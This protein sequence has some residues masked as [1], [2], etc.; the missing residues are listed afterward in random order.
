ML[1]RAL[2]GDRPTMSSNLQDKFLTCRNPYSGVRTSH[3]SA[4]TRYRTH[5]PVR[6]ET[7]PLPEAK[8]RQ[9]SL[10][11]QLLYA[12]GSLAFTWLERMIILYAAFFYLPPA[13]LG[14]PSLISTRTY[15]GIFTVLGLS[16]LF[17]RILDGLADPVIAFLSDRSRS[18]WG[19]RKYFLLLSALPLA[20]TA[21]LVFFPPRPYA[22]PYNGLWLAFMLGAFYVFFTAYVNPY[23]S[24]I[25]GLG[26]SNSARVNLSTYMALFG[27]VGM[28]VVTVA[29]PLAIGQLQAMGY[30]LRRAYQLAASASAVLG[31]MVLYGAASAF[32][33]RAHCLPIQPPTLNLWTSARR[34]LEVRPFRLF[35]TAEVF[36]QY[37]MNLVTLGLMYFTVVLFRRQP[38]FLTVLAGTTIGAALVS[39]PLVNVMSKRLGKKRLIAFAMSTLALAMCAMLL[40]SY[41]LS[42]AAFYAGIGLFAISGIPLAILT[43]LINPTI[44]ELARA[45]AL[46][47]GQHCEAMFFAVRSI[48]LKLSIAAAGLSFG[49]LL[50]RFGKD[51]ADPGGVRASLFLVSLAAILGYACFARYPE[52]QV[53]A[54]LRE[55]EG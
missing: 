13:E 16:L 54:Q 29:F 42:G 2:C 24:L 5:R 14:L 21:A 11:G 43:I 34:T 36:L 55:Y 45:E 33:E 35:I 27:L 25:S 1:H 23:L 26:H 9:L 28:L 10:P 38:Q 17:G 32:G 8:F 50:S 44:A 4:R 12:S 15:G 6:S 48:P 7:G 37:A 39:F 51:V 3:R 49:F 20:G 41:D 31:V 22:S 52:E 53:Q 30:T 40:L 19:R 47:S 46:R 18:R